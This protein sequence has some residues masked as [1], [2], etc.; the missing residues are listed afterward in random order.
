MVS[1]GE[2]NTIVASGEGSKEE[3]GKL[4]KKETALLRLFREN[5]KGR[6][7][8]FSRYDNPFLAMESSIEALGIKVK[9]LKGNKDAIA[10][11]LRQFQTGDLRCLLLNSNYAGSGLNI[12]AAIAVSNAH[13]GFN[14]AIDIPDTGIIANNSI[15][16]PLLGLV[17][18]DYFDWCPCQG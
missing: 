16:D 9:Q 4:E 7:L 8:V 12:T 13:S 10:S 2:K 17:T 5:P 6:F 3:E 11:T 14:F 18:A 1:Q 15:A